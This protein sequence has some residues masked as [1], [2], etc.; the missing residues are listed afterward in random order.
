MRVGYNWAR[1]KGLFLR[2][3]SQLEKS[4]L[5]EEIAERYNIGKDKVFEVLVR[6]ISYPLFIALVENNMQLPNRLKG[7]ALLYEIK[8][9]ESFIKETLKKLLHCL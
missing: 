2:N 6:N 9:F 8:A 7:I 1:S 3:L 4:R 5:I